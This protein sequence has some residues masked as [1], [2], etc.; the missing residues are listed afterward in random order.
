[1]EADPRVA[2]DFEGMQAKEELTDQ[3]LAK[4]EEV[5]K[6]MDQLRSCHESYDLVKKL[7]DKDTSDA[8]KE[9]SETMK[10]ELDRISKLVFRDE[11]VQGIY[12]PSDALSV[13]MRG[14]YSITGASRPLTTN[15][16]QK[17]DQLMS[18]ADETLE[19]ISSFIDNEW[20]EYRDFVNKM[21]V[22]LFQ[23]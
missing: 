13:R 16:L 4:L 2:Y 10:K 21:N 18:L 14:I 17:Y 11:S 12:Y 7:A 6:A 3:L 15:Q 19:M 9:T 23:N 5:N 20:Q 1:V 22:P 8:F